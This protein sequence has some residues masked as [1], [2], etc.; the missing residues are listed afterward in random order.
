MEYV[1]EQVAKRIKY[2]RELLELSYED[3]AQVTGVKA[4]EYKACEDGET[5]FSFTF[6]YKCAEK[7]GIDLSELLTG[8]MPKLS[9]Y[10]IVRK[11]KGLSVKRRSGL[12]YNHL[13]YLFKK[14]IAEPFVVTALYNQEE[15]NKEI[16]LSTHEGQEM[17]YILKGQ[18]K[19]RF[20]NHTEILNEGDCA[21]YDSSHGH[22][23]IAA[24][25][26]DCVFLAIVMKA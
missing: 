5:D 1:I 12:E 3:M 7:F 18:L 21:Y 16:E 13:A 14:R 20:E 23:M 11:G 10:S 22:G 8:E 17:D 9:F 2:M 6:L 15:Q 24:G 19:I 26:Q 25:G 4:Q